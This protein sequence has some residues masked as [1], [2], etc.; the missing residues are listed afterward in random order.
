MRALVLA[1]AFVSLVVLFLFVFFQ[2]GESTESVTSVLTSTDQKPEPV[3]HGP[4]VEEPVSRSQIEREFLPAGGCLT[5]DQFYSHPRIAEEAARLAPFSATMSEEISAYRGLTEDELLPLIQQGDSAAMAVMGAIELMR[6]RSEPD[7]KAVPYLMLEGGGYVR[8]G[9]ISADQIK[10]YEKA[11]E[12]FY[13]AALNG[14]VLALINLGEVLTL[15]QKTPLKLGWVS[16]ED[17]S[18]M[19]RE[20]QLV[21]NAANVYQGLAYTIAPE[22]EIGLFDEGYGTQAA[23]KYAEIIQ[24]LYDRF[25]KD[26]VQRGLPP[27][28][29]PES[30]LPPLSELDGIICEAPE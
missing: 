24:P 22:L 21:F 15:Q 14:R 26:R 20:Q 18:S 3:D 23:Q 13:E 8:H 2:S 5:E 30:K 16:E 11:I 17:F 29:V 7:S 6:G 27:I 25:E 28:A 1:S 12:W 9:P 4:L 19:T 10:H